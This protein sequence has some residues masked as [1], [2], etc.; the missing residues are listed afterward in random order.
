M[1]HSSYGSLMSS[2]KP[3]LTGEL[4]IQHFEFPGEAKNALSAP[5]TEFAVL[6]MKSGKPKDDVEKLLDAISKELDATQ[7]TYLP[8]LWGPCIEDR[9]TF[10][11]LVGWDT[12]EVRT[13]RGNPSSADVEV[14]VFQTHRETVKGDALESLIAHIF[15]LV[16][17]HLSHVKLLKH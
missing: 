13:L 15:E 8:T 12:V 17:G 1:Q 9:N 3:A 6:T 11:M 5:V 2:L 4:A 14:N 7:R 16:D 10:L